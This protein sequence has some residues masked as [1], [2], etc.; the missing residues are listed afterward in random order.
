[1]SIASDL[2][3]TD[4][5][6]DLPPGALDSIAAL[7]RP[8]KLDEGD[9]LYTLGDDAAELFMLQ[10]GRIRFS[11]GVSNR[12][13]TSGAIIKPGKVFGWA[14][15]LEGEPRRVATAAC[16]EDSVVQVFSSSQLLDYFENDKPV[17]YLVMRRLA[18]LVANDFL[19]VMAV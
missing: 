17:G 2:A 16:L 19:S 12:P 18:T 13:G 10:E 3:M 5:F 9:T 15:L 4:L 6:Q 1:M 14:A 8:K 11:L 7:A